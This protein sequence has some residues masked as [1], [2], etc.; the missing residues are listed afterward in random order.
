MASIILSLFAVLADVVDLTKLV[1][2]E[3]TTSLLREGHLI[4]S[5]IDVPCVKH[6]ISKA[7]SLGIIVGSGILKVPQ[8]I[9]ILRSGTV[10][11][12]SPASFYL[13]T[14]SYLATIVYNVIHEKPFMTYGEAIIIFIQNIILGT[15]FR[16]TSRGGWLG[17]HVNRSLVA[18]IKQAATNRTSRKLHPCHAQYNLFTYSFPCI[19]L[20]YLPSAA[21]V[22]A[23]GVLLYLLP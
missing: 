3:C 1:K 11:G 6:C 4:F 22:A 14:L 16:E 13:E 5:P 21:A 7:L 9:A 12:L 8:I 17:G 10:K 20:L 23:A 15:L 18:G 2:P 19:A